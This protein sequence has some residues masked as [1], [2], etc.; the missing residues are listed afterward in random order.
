MLVSG[1][2]SQVSLPVSWEE[3]P[4]GG[5]FMRPKSPFSWLMLSGAQ[6]EFI[7]ILS[8]RHTSCPAP[9]WAIQLL[10]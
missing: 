9:Q 3:A 1:E 7:I 2:L 4:P 5:P 10:P 6:A 8:L